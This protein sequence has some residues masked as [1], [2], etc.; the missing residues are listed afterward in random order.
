MNIA[1]ITPAA[2]RTR[3]GNRNTAVRWSRLL[4][5]LGHQVRLEQHWSGTPAAV[6]IALHARR[7]HDSVLRY[8]ERWPQRPLVVTL[9]GTDLYR[10]IRNDATAQLSLEFATRLIVLHELGAAALPSRHRGKTR[11]VFQSASA[12]ARRPP[13]A[14][15]FEV[16]VCG[17]L[18]SEKDPFR[19]AAALEHLPGTSRIRVTHLGGAL[20]PDMAQE[21]R[22]WM[23]RE[24]R[25]RWL[26][27][28]AHWQTMRI[29]A[30]SPLMVISSVMEGGANV[31]CEALAARTP[32]VASRIP[33]NVG[34]L[35]RDYPGYYPLSNERRL[36][37][38]LSR[39]E[40]DAIFYDA[41]R[42][43]CDAR[44]ALVTPRHEQQALAAVL[45]EC[46]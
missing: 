5:G 8:A 19:A 3:L 42:R 18:R 22:S 27:E 26:G 2:P 33:G 32:V 25:Y 38:I 1:L 44:R 10:D 41:L 35:G 36:A 12:A 37:R 15:C 24:P 31:V 9:T 4:R 29:L 7:S 46:R 28:R 30:R 23:A 16:V 45:R 11:I 17:H 39:A 6:M 20:H 14:S 13:L 34:M 43:G 40:T 21:A